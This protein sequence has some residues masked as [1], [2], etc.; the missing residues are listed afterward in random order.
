MLGLALLD[1]AVCGSVGCAADDELP[2]GRINAVWLKPG[3]LAMQRG[4]ESGCGLFDASK[5]V[6]RLGA[7]CI[8][9]DPDSIGVSGKVLPRHE[10]V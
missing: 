2:S 5:L 7:A 1:P 8:G 3:L 10:S 9:S 6:A 4:G